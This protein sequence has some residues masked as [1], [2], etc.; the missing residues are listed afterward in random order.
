M[1][2]L[3]LTLLDFEDINEHNIYTDLLRKF[4]REGHNIYV[5][6]P[7]ERK[8]RLNT[9]FIEQ[10]DRIHILKLKI[11]NIQKTNLLEKGLSTLLLESQFKAGIIKYFLEVKFDL[12]LY[13]TPPITL[14]KAVQFIK[15]RDGSVAYLMLKDIFPQGALDLKMLT[16]RGVKG[17]IYHYFRLKEKRLYKEADF[18]G[19]MSEANIKYI[20]KHNNI[21]EDKVELCPNCIEISEKVL[22]PSQ[23]INN[24]LLEKY[25]IPKNKTIFVYGG[26]LGKPQGVD[27][28][29]ECLKRVEKLEDAFLLIVGSGTEYNKLYNEI[30][31]NNMKNVK[32]IRYLPKNEYDTL[33]SIC[34]VGLLFLNYNLTVPNI[35]SRLLAYMDREM[36]VLA[37]VDESTDVD[38]IIESGK[39][40]W[41]C[42]SNSVDK[43]IQLIEKASRCENRKELGENA[44]RYLQSNFGVDIA[45]A[46]I[47]QHFIK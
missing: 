15:R 7:V 38:K 41:T 25:H 13:S 5:V 9:W 20:L 18:I 12:V 44:K 39:F 17:I 29:I 23:K 43:V 22:S 28:V 26:N 35:P 27:F 42:K 16:R 45:Y 4:Y 10:D 30:I 33:L 11:G 2:L 32:L 1:N 36:P 24:D 40:G 21:S 37:A 6:S 31:G 19:C 8:R 34:D 3:F 47:M 46:Q 14:Q